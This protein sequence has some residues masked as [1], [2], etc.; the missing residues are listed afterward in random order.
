MKNQNEK[1]LRNK[2]LVEIHLA[3]FLFGLAGLFG[4]LLN[5]PPII[6]VLGRVFFSSLFLFILL[7]FTTTSL[8]IK[9]K[10]DYFYLLM[11]GFILAVHWIT[12]FKAIQAA[13]VAVGLLTFST[14]PL[15]VTVMEP[16]LFKEK[17]KL[18]DVLIAV[19]AFLG[20]ILIIPDFKLRS[21]IA[22]GALWGMLSGFSYAVLSLFNRKYVKKYSGLTVAFYEQVLATL[23]LIPFYFV[24]E[25]VFQIKDIVMLALLGIVF[26]AVSHTMFIRG[27]KYVKAKTAGIISCLEP[28]YGI[29]FAIILFGDI[30]SMREIFGGIIILSSVL[31]A[32]VKSK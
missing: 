15:F 14:F 20:V 8:K 30:L 4:K 2:S 6:I 26:T 16:F 17:L 19:A 1:E 22:Q 27:L 32:M 9:Q 25:P 12:F 28:V 10:Q 23:I 13:T 11:M 5:F 3:V 31:F 29:T 7:L 21:T 24:Y 18:A